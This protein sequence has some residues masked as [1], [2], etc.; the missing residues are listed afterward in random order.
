MDKIWDRKSM[1]V[2]GRWGRDGKNKWPCREDCVGKV[3]DFCNFLSVED[4]ICIFSFG[5]GEQ[6]D[7]STKAVCL[8]PVYDVLWR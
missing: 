8:D 7:L 5:S 3:H 2:I 6:I 4:C 1:K